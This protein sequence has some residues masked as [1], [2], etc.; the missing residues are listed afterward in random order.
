VVC[1]SDADLDNPQYK[2][3]AV[4]HTQLRVQALQ[5]LPDGSRCD[6]QLDGDRGP[7]F[8]CTGRKA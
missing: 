4:F 7:D 5:V 3:N 2:A 6:V 1:K 8:H